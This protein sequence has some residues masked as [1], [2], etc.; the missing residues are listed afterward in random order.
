MLTSFMSEKCASTGT[1]VYLMPVRGCIDH[2]TLV[3]ICKYELRAAE[4]SITEDDWREY[5]LS[6]RQPEKID[7]GLVK[8]AMRGLKMKTTH[9]DSTSRIVELTADF[10]A[11]LDSMDLEWFTEQEPKA[12]V[13]FLLNALEPRVFRETIRAELE[14]Q[15]NAKY[16]KSVPDFLDWIGPQLK[17]L[18]RFDVEMNKTDHRPPNPGVPKGPAPNKP[19]RSDGRPKHGPQRDGAPGKKEPP[20]GP[21][22]AGSGA[23]LK[24]GSR[25][26][27]VFNC[28]DATAEE[29]KSLWEKHKR[30]RREKPPVVAASALSAG[31]NDE[32][33][34][35]RAIANNALEVTVLTDYGAAES[36]VSPTCIDRLLSQDPTFQVH[37]LDAPIEVLS[38]TGGKVQIKREARIHLAFHLV[39]RSCCA[40]SYVGLRTSP[41]PPALE[42]FC[43]VGVLC[44]ASATAL[45][46]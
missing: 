46:S 42:M 41:C 5:F 7:I 3:R 8:A 10:E 22:K 45:K 11:I 44:V 2:K 13:R 24:C 4:D 33:V 18:L 28:P 37:T 38:F 9:A 32:R 1:Q 19:P 34:L 36:V 27:G 12:S 6:A 14:M 23:C 35:L 29:A 26:H 30:E 40:M 21:A 17:E 39:A 25:D 15:S 20:A 43:S 16:R 31:A